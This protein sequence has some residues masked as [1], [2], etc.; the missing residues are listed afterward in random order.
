MIEPPEIF[1]ILFVTLGPLKV[2][3]P[4]AHRTSGIDDS[5]VKAIAVRAFIIATIAII[6]G[7]I[8]GALTLAK[9]HVSIGALAL[10]AGIIFFL[11]ALRQLLEQYEPE[12]AAPPEPLPASPTA[13]A[14]QLVFPI[15]LTPYGIAVVIALVAASTRAERT[16]MILALLLLVMILNLL[17]MW[18]V[19][20]ILTG[21][22]MLI[23][24]LVGAVLAVLQVALAIEF[25][26][27]GLRSL[28]VI[29]G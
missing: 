21:L 12:P 22:T 17:A 27:M 11:V 19:R 26:L 6:A 2:L 13:A 28:H 15:V 8:F 16:E 29:S 5:A 10:A 4:F 3:G 20:R 18:F 1:T 9:W 24:Q 25:I 14:C 7:G 23:L